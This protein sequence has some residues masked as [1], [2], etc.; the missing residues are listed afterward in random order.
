MVNLIPDPKVPVY[1]R[2]G[3]KS[4]NT[5]GYRGVPCSRLPAEP[6]N[7]RKEERAVEFR[8]DLPKKRRAKSTLMVLT[9]EFTVDNQFSSVNLIWS[10]QSV[11]QQIEFSKDYVASDEHQFITQNKIFNER[12][13]IASTFGTVIFNFS[14]RASEHV[15]HL[16]CV[17]LLRQFW[18]E[19]QK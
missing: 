14:F 5:S 3:W 2:K 11:K 19:V 1:E 12:V 16:V 7:P 18:F 6:E 10:F 15:R 13:T 8:T 9:Q 4:W 17:F